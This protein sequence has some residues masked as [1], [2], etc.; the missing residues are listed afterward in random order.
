[1][2]IWYKCINVFMNHLPV[3][4]SSSSVESSSL[5]SSKSLSVITS[6]LVY[7][8]SRLKLDCILLNRSSFSSSS[9]FRSSIESF[10]LPR[11][12][13][14]FLLRSKI[15]SHLNLLAA[16][17]VSRNR[18]GLFDYIIGRKYKYGLTECFQYKTLIAG[19]SRCIERPFYRQCEV[20]R[21][22]WARGKKIILSVVGR[23][24]L[25]RTLALFIPLHHDVFIT[26]FSLHSRRSTNEYSGM[27]I[28]KL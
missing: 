8:L 6:S 20:R 21:I 25:V 13:V 22:F 14:C 15:I 10:A 28:F 9:I 17:F 27:V 12:L 26:N 19:R 1:M 2:C 5:N 23:F 3:F 7:F 11:F 24:P 4:S 16:A 18:S